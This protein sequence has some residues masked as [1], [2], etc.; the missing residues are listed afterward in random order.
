MEKLFYIGLGG[1]IGA[2]LRYLVS[3]MFYSYFEGYFPIGTLAVNLIGAFAI[4]FLWYIFEHTVLFA[5]LRAFVLVGTLG[6]FTTLS[7]YGLETFNLLRDGEVKLA[8]LNVFFTTFC[9][10]FFV[11]MGFW[12][13]KIVLGRGV[14]L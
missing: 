12:L 3:G 1:A 7:T 10:V 8:I 9:G 6:A 5:N 13:A 11:F 14:S 4:G 2:I